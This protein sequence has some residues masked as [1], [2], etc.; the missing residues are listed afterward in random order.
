MISAST[1]VTETTVLFFH[2][3][4]QN[5][6]RKWLFDERV[7]SEQFQVLD[8]RMKQALELQAFCEKSHFH[9]FMDV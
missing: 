6:K 3:V 8:F 7:A 2:V 9:F 1:G 4:H 5:K